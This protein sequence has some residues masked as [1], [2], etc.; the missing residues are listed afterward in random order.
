MEFFDSKLND[1]YLDWVNNYV[2]YEKFAEHNGVSVEFAKELIY[3]I[4]AEREAIIDE[5][6]RGLL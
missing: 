5:Y 4:Q 6:K 1:I 3:M 2:T